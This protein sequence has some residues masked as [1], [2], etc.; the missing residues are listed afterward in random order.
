MPYLSDKEGRNFNHAKCPFHNYDVILLYYV[1]LGRYLL[2][3][4]S[5]GHVDAVLFISF[6]KET[7]RHIVLST[8]VKQLAIFYANLVRKMTV[9]YANFV[10]KMTI[11]D[12]NLVRKM[13]MVFKQFFFILCLTKTTLTF[14]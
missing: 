11:F 10:R 2:Q 8:L 13:T 14:C 5:F 7:R 1:F 6:L 4:I 9:F 12:A 3:T